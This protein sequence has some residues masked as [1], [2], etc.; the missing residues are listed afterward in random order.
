MDATTALRIMDALAEKIEVL[1]ERVAEAEKRL[2]DKCSCE[3]WVRNLR[4][5]VDG[6]EE[7]D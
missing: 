2:A 7:P 4:K 6:P 3:K 5:N 1:T